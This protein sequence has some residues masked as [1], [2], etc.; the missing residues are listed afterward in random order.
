MATEKFLIFGHRGQDGTLLRKSLASQGKRVVGIGR[1]SVD[2]Y[3]SAGLLF[4][5]HLRPERI[6]PLVKNLAPEEIYYLSAVHTSSE[7]NL[8]TTSSLSSFE[9]YQRVGVGEY[10]ELLDAVHS[11]SKGSR[12]FY[13]GSSHVYGP[14]SKRHLTE[15]SAFRPQS[16][17]G[18]AKAQGIW[19]SQKYRVQS[20]LNVSSGILFNHESHLRGNSFFTTRLI[21]GAI[22]VAR[23]EVSS[24]ALGNLDSRA[25]WGHAEDFVEAFQEIVRL[26]KPDDFVV[27]TGETR[28]VRDFV[29]VVFEYFGLGWE[30]HLQVDRSLVGDSRNIEEAKPAKILGS[31]AW[32]PRQDFEHF[33]HRLIEDHLADYENSETSN[34]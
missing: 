10:V 13:A 24:V 11:H 25:D 2:F 15:K 19:L 32:R 16:F 27:A 23:D 6:G 18:M 14:G 34:Q 22:E 28:S 17:Y 4:E 20:G 12:V 8:S 26:Q 9:D 5:S 33:V 21:R 3:D 31:T 1:Q 7:G 29:Q 30:E